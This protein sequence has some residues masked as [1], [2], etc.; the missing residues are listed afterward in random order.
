MVYIVNHGDEELVLGVLQ[1]DFTKLVLD[2]SDSSC[3]LDLA[4][5]VIDPSPFLALQF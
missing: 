2:V 5:M 1:D 4:E 3:R